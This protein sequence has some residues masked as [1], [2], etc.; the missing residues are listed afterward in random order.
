METPIC[1]PR[2]LK[3]AMKMIIEDKN[4]SGSEFISTLKSFNLS[5]HKGMIEKLIGLEEGYL[6]D[7]NH[8]G[9]VHLL[10]RA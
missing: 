5:L 4:V 9:T 8:T 3:H 6:G 1:K 10:N 7:N 2:Y